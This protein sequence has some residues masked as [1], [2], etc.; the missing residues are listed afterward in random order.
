MTADSSE[1]H[2]RLVTVR[3]LV[4]DLLRY[5]NDE[6]HQQQNWRKTLDIYSRL[7]VR[8]IQCSTHPVLHQLRV[9]LTVY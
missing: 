3:S 2:C 4:A 1:E 6:V 8:P 5:V 9:C 7:D